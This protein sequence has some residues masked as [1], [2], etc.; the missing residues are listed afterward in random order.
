MEGVNVIAEPV[1]VNMV[2]KVMTVAVLQTRMLAEKM[3]RSAPT[4]ESVSAEDVLVE[5]GLPELSVQWKEPV[6]KRMDLL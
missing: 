4:M 6:M 5:M 2:S 1:N 3:G